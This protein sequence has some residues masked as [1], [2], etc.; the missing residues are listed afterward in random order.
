[1]KTIFSLLALLT[2]FSPVVAMEEGATDSACKT[3][4]VK[5]MALI[6]LSYNLNEEGRFGIC[7]DPGTDFECVGQQVRDELNALLDQG[8]VLPKPKDNLTCTFKLLFPVAFSQEDIEQLFDQ[9]SRQLSETNKAEPEAESGK[10]LLRK[11]LDSV[12]EILRMEKLRE[13]SS[14]KEDS[15]D[16]DLCERVSRLSVHPP[17]DNSHEKT[18][19]F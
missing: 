7:P 16:D 12:Q 2:A 19:D 10:E 18:G 13:S 11:L 17:C 15:D 14:R 5:K 1:M 4:V 6:H 9:L 3:V 8:K